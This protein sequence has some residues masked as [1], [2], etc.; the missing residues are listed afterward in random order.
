MKFL[1]GVV[2]GMVIGRP[3]L[4]AVNDHLTPPVRRRI[5][6]GVIKVY[7]RIGESLDKM[8]EEEK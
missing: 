7:N 6:N 5:K 3:V 2:V 4:A 8:E 1:A